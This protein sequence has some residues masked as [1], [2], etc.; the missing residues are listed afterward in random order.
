M[1]SFIISRYLLRFLKTELQHSVAS[2]FKRPKPAPAARGFDED[3]VEGIS[4]RHVELAA[5]IF[6]RSLLDEEFALSMRSV[7][8]MLDLD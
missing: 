4:R 7:E 3:V 6:V 5:D 2:L 1:S 8:S